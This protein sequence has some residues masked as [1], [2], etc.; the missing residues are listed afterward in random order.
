VTSVPLVTRSAE[1]SQLY[2]ELQ[3]CPQCAAT[4]LEITAHWQA[5]D[6]GGALLS[7]YESRCAECGG[8][9]EFE[10]AAPDEP[11]APPRFGGPEPSRLIDAGQFLAVARELAAAVPADPAQCPA[12]ERADAREAMAMAVSAVT[13]VRKFLPADGNEVPP[14]A[15]FTAAGRAL[16]GADPVQFTRRRLTALDNGYRRILAAY[17]AR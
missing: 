11:P 15:F 2:L 3:S 16:Y 13:E 7:C 9:A 14:E 10:F 12:E 8:G 1:E 6:A 5:E 17:E 4:A